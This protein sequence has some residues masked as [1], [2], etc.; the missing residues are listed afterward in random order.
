MSKEAIVVVDFGSSALKVQ[1]FALNGELIVESRRPLQLIRDEASLAVEYDPLETEAALFGCLR[2]VCDR[3]RH[4]SCS[5]KGVSCTSQRYNMVLLDSDGREICISPNVDPRGFLAGLELDE[6]TLVEVYR[7]TGLHPPQL[8]TPAR[9]KWFKEFKPDTYS[10]IS[11]V[12]TICDWVVY[13]LCRAF[14]TSPS[15]AASTMVF[16]VVGRRWSE[17]MIDIFNVERDWLPDVAEEGGTAGFVT[18]DVARE[19]G[20]PIGSPVVNCGGDTHSA[21]VA[22]RAYSEGE[23][24]VVAGHT[25]PVAAYVGEPVFD[26]EMR[27]WLVPLLGGWFVESNAGP[28]GFL[29]DWFL[30]SIDASGDYRLLDALFESSEPGARGVLM[31]LHPSIMDSRSLGRRGFRSVIAMPPLASPFTSVVRACDMARALLE[32]TTYSIKANVVQA[33]SVASRKLLRVKVTG[34]LT[35]L[36]SIRKLLPS[37]LGVDTLSTEHHYGSGL[38]SVA[39]AAWR[40]GYY[41]SLEDAARALCPL[42]KLEPDEELGRCYE[43]LYASWLDFYTGTQS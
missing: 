27:T 18:G 14:A 42:V 24:G 19:T 11:K 13:K 20:L 33:A 28:L 1:A 6:E 38:G 31:K 37:A 21:M 15:M 26:A 2:A 25:A 10:R 30:R 29:V 8:F 17:K 9:L 41:S 36:S 43:E 3:L 39:L 23:V 34:G 22:M 5:V 40:L 4:L 7:T 12:L 32:Y 35:R 16:D